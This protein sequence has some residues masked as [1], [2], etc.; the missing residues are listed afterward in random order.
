[1][2]AAFHCFGD[3]RD[4][5]RSPWLVALSRFIYLVLFCSINSKAG[6]HWLPVSQRACTA[7]ERKGTPRYVA[8]VP[9][10]GPE[11][12]SRVE[13]HFHGRRA[14]GARF[15]SGKVTSGRDPENIHNDSFSACSVPGQVRQADKR[16]QK[17]RHRQERAQKEALSIVYT[18]CLYFF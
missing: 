14:H 11:S 13:K 12:P 10:G 16:G 5:P 18:S 9:E 2:I 4:T 17:Q 15:Y 8:A 3:F 1:M 7:S 6:N